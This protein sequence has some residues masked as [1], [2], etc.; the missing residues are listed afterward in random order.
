M[1]WS[2]V[3]AVVIERSEQ[4]PDQVWRKRWQDLLINWINKVKD[5]V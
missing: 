2:R 5:Q 1:A 3:R 4:N